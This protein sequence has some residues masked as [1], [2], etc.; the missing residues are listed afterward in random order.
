MK[1]E[2]KT[3]DQ[4]IAELAEM[5]QRVVELETSDTE[6]RQAEQTLRMYANQQTVLYAVASA[7]ATSLDP[8]ELLGTVLNKVLL[9]LDA[10]AGWVI[11]PGPTLD[12]PGQL[13]VSLGVPES[14]RAVHSML[15]M[16]DCPVCGPMLLG[17]TELAEPMIMGECP[18]LPPEV[19]ASTGLHSHVGIPLYAGKDL[20]GILNIAWGSHHSYAKSDR[21]L[22][23]AIGRQVGVAL[24]NAQLYQAARQVDGLRVINELQRALGATLDL[25]TVAETILRRV[26]AA[27]GA[28]VS[29]LLYLPSELSVSPG[30]VFA[31]DGDWTAAPISEKDL[32][33]IRPLL[34]RLRGHEVVALSSDELAI[35]SDRHR[36]LTRNWVSGLVAPIR[37]DAGMVALLALGGRAVE[38]PFTEEDV[39]LMEAVAGHVGQAIQNAQLYLASQAQSERLFALNAIGAA[40]VST[41]D[42]DTILRLI[43]EL[44]CQVLDAMAGSIL[45]SDP[46]TGQMRFAITLER[47]TSS[48]H[49]RHLAPGQGIANWVAA[50]AQSVSVDDVSQDL[51]WSSDIDAVIGFETHSLMCAPMK[52]RGEVT[53]VIE[54]VNKRTGAFTGEELSL[55]EA[56]CATAATALENARLFETTKARA[57]ELAL[58]NEIGLAL[59]SSLDRDQIVDEALGRVQRLFQSDGTV[60]LK[61]VPQTG[62]IQVARAMVGEAFT[63]VSVQLEPGEGV[64]G[65]VLE[66]RRAVLMEDAGDQPS[67]FPYRLEPSMGGRSRAMMAVPVLIAN[68]VIAILGVFSHRVAKYSQNDLRMLEAV[69]VTLAASLENARLYEELRLSLRERELTQ[70]QL[71]HAEKMAALGRLTASIAHEINNPLQA[72]QGCLTLVQEDLDRQPP[73]AA[74]PTRKYLTVAQSEIDR[75]GDIVQRTRDFYRPSRGGKWEVD[76]HEVLE[77]VLTL[78][79]K[80]LEQANITVR[81]KWAESLPAIHANADHLKQVFLNLVLNAIDAMSS[82]GTLC[83]S[84]SP[85]QMQPSLEQHTRGAAR[86]DFSDTGEG[87]TS[88]QLSR[89]FEPFFTTKPQGTGLGLSITYG[90]VHAHQ[91]TIS[92]ESQRGKGTTFSV[93]LPVEQP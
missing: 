20:L 91:G 58:L 43:L 9:A 13:T 40:A 32:K 15:R 60:L 46:D 65:Q 57:G 7:V 45:L 72:V 85:D 53:G 79:G 52:H 61:P 10:E 70:A 37:D 66:Q 31:L 34:R 5:R 24:H 55:L 81:R 87:L 49:G 23:T 29:V 42:R 21:A 26:S 4:L 88:E 74:E 3:R 44:T 76:L 71:V 18:C 25:E 41:L 14:F 77:S 2:A 68:H 62:Q 30:R 12:E 56:A 90:I 6:R 84:T 93:L 27:L 28:P 36:D 39:A 54:I 50:H 86:V 92:V 17:A 89:V 33:R 59:G 47:G 16:R 1:D 48:L 64:Y 80:R 67:L 51:R 35:I 63:E 82:G 75:I 19:W 8:D 22:L 11:L 38:Q 69:G 83:V 78:T 73:R